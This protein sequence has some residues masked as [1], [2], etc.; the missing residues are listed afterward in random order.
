MGNGW[1]SL[2]FTS[3]TSSDIL[4]PKTSTFAPFFELPEQMMNHCMAAI[5]DTHVFLA[6]GSYGTGQQ[7]IISQVAR[8]YLLTIF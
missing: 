7:G 4:I 2:V 1:V 6:G 8:L 3:F 5:N